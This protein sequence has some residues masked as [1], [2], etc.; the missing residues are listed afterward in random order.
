MPQNKTV[1]FSSATLVESQVSVEFLLAAT[2]EFPDVI[3]IK[4]HDSIAGL[5]YNLCVGSQ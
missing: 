4:N 3:G 2:M 1:T 5:L